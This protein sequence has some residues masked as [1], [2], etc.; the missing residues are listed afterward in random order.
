MTLSNQFPVI[1]DEFGT[2][3]ALRQ[4]TGEFGETGYEGT[5]PSSGDRVSLSMSKDEWGHSEIRGSIGSQSLD[6][7]IGTDEFGQTEIRGRGAEAYRRLTQPQPDPF[8]D[9]M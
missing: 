9:W 4:T 7:Y 2:R 5:D 8:T 3:P 6:V 1:R